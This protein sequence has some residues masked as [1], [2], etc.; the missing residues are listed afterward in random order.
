MTQCTA[1]IITLF[2]NDMFFFQELLFID[3]QSVAQMLAKY[4][5]IIQSLSEPE[6]SIKLKAFRERGKN[7]VP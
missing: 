1:Y 7:D 4:N 5:N 3:V 6:V 2:L